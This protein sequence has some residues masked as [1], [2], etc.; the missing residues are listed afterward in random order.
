M[1]LNDSALFLLARKSFVCAFSWV[2]NVLEEKLDD[3][4]IFFALL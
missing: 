1:L 2:L 3:S 4:D